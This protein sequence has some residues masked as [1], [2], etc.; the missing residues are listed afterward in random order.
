MS[1]VLCHAKLGDS[2]FPSIKGTSLAQGTAHGM[3]QQ[4]W[5]NQ[6][7][8]VSRRWFSLALWSSADCSSLGACPSTKS[9]PGTEF[10]V[11]R[12]ICSTRKHIANDPIEIVAAGAASSEHSSI[13]QP[14]CHCGRCAERA[15]G[16]AGTATVCV[17]VQITELERQLCSSLHC[18][19]HVLMPI[20]FLPI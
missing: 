1:T 17:S 9:A 14:R 6:R 19:P 4:T 16:N 8:Q 10:K 2:T 11:K 18:F 3:A 12:N 5:R 20:K 13:S 7:S 15:S